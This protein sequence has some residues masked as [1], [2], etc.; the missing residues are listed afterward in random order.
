MFAAILLCGTV[1]MITSCSFNEDN[2]SSSSRAIPEGGDPKDYQPSD[3]SVALLGSLG[4]YADEEVVRYWF[5]VDSGKDIILALPANK[6][7]DIEI[8]MGKT[9]DDKKKYVLHG[10]EAASYA[11]VDAVKTSLFTPAK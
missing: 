11:K 1:T 3:F 6:E 8:W 9:W 4:C 10:W 5:T 7:Y 2:P